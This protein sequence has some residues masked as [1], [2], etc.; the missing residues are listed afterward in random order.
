MTITDGLWSRRPRSWGLAGP[1]VQLGA[2]AASFCPGDDGSCFRTGT[3]TGMTRGKRLSSLGHFVFM[4]SVLAGLHGRWDSCKTRKAE[5]QPGLTAFPFNITKNKGPEKTAQ[6]LQGT[7]RNFRIEAHLKSKA[8][9]DSSV[10]LVSTR[11]LQ[12]SPHLLIY[13]EQNFLIL[14]QKIK[15]N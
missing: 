6:E 12:I 10:Y 1:R 5:L 11:W 15:P 7:A 9:R 8:A 2:R 3:D 14:Q 4:P 13:L